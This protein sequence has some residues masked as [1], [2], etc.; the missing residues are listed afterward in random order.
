M[1]KAYQL[2]LNNA[3]VDGK[4]GRPHLKEYIERGWISE[5]DVKE[6]RLETVAKAAVTKTQE[7]AYDDY[8]TA[9]LAKALGDSKITRL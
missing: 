4:G 6:P 2:L 5:M 3:F 1:Q 7:Y 8:A 9:L